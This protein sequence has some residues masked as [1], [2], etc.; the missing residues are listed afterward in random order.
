MKFV[1]LQIQTRNG[2]AFTNQEGSFEM[3]C[4]RENLHLCSDNLPIIL[5]V[6]LAF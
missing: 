5:L 3:F 6:F 4:H 2:M 1:F